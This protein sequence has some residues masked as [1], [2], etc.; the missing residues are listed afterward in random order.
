MDEDD[1]DRADFYRSSLVSAG[2][3]IPADETALFTL[4]LLLDLTKTL[5]KLAE[6]QGVD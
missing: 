4:G 6:H 2:I 5:D 3:P 1:R